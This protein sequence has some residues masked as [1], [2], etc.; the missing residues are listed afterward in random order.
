MFNYT[1][2]DAFRELE[3]LNE[4]TFSLDDTGL[5]D[6]KDFIENDESS[7][8]VINVIDPEAEN[9]D[10]LK[11]S[12]EGDVIL[13]CSVC[14]QD[15]YKSP[16]DVVIS[17]SEELANIDETC[18][19]CYST[20]GFY[21]IG[22]VAPYPP[23]ESEEEKV[24]DSEKEVV[25][26]DYSFEDAF[27]E[28]LHST[29]RKR[30]NRRGI[31][32]SRK[33]VH[34]AL[35]EKRTATLAD[36]IMQLLDGEFYDTVISSKTGKPQTV[37]RPALYASDTI[38]VDGKGLTILVKDEADASPAQEIADKFNLKT[39]YEPPKSWEKRD[40]RGIFH[41]YIPEKDWD[42][43]V[44]D[45]VFGE[46]LSEGLAS[47]VCWEVSSVK[48]R[49]SRLQEAADKSKPVT[50][51]SIIS[52]IGKYLRLDYRWGY[53]RVKASPTT[54]RAYREEAIYYV[55]ISILR[56]NLSKVDLTNLDEYKLAETVARIFDDSAELRLYD[57]GDGYE[58]YDDAHNYYDKYRADIKYNFEEEDE[59]FKALKAKILGES[60]KYAKASSILPHLRNAYKQAKAD[61]KEASRR[62]AHASN[63]A[64]YDAADLDMNK[65]ANKLASIERGDE[66]HSL[67]ESVQNVTIATD[68][69][70]V[71]VVPS[72]DDGITI[73]AQ[74]TEQSD[75]EII[76]SEET[77]VPIDQSTMDEIESN[78]EETLDDEPVSNDSESIDI[79]NLD[80]D[81]EDFNELGESYLR[82]VYNNVDSYSTS[83]V[84][85][86]NN[87]LIF[88]GVITFSSGKK[89]KTS[90]IFE[91]AGLTK[92]GKL[93]LY[94]RNKHL[95]N[96]NKAFTLTSAI[97]E[98]KGVL[99]SLNYNYLAKDSV[100]GKSVKMYGTVRKH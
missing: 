74:P 1:I 55:P 61:H 96:N 3:L 87:G 92:K 88:E 40:R 24:V 56:D 43:D 7:V 16:E 90:F 75:V 73:T 85:K 99:E 19:N 37:A 86:T 51:D 57:H 21:I 26:T 77:I 95:S 28:S 9:E 89:A 41:I 14:K 52:R 49:R 81:E 66:S 30:S 100:S 29:L 62:R 42:K 67:D 38:G 54:V 11:D 13:R 36:T 33:K 94:G 78:S 48:S 82:K 84:K 18:P 69:D 65:T 58:G 4:D 25:D 31:R 60:D 2:S 80:I 93:K 27:E 79:E 98:N 46:N 64:E 45:I 68:T 59:E 12:Y 97:K 15:M 71:E 10:E 63:Y 17:E 76:S 8:E 23:E 70:I 34:E 6:L 47:N 32:D 83:A 72:G 91:Q 53:R 5:D 50:V 22:Q 35:N 44:T 39:F 20:D